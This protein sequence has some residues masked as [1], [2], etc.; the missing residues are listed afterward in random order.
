M[1]AWGAI[2]FLAGPVSALSL[3]RLWVCRPE[4]SVALEQESLSRALFRS[5]RAMNA[6][7]D[8]LAQAA[9]HSRI[10]AKKAIF[11]EIGR[12]ERLKNEMLHAGEK[13][14][15]PGPGEWGETRDETLAVLERTGRYFGRNVPDRA[16]RQ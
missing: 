15:Y 9:G 13:L 8:R 5:L 14:R 4:E 7:L 2:N 3:L 11:E 6:E 12:I 10:D 1:D 16:E